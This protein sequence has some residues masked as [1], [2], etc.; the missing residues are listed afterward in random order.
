MGLQSCWRSW[1]GKST[2][3]SPRGPM[4]N[5]TSQP[6]VLCELAVP[7]FSSSCR[8]HLF[9]EDLSLTK[10]T[11]KILSSLSMNAVVAFSSPDFVSCSF[12][13]ESS[14]TCC[15]ASA[16]SKRE[17]FFTALRS[18]SSGQPSLWL[19]TPFCL[20]PSLV[21]PSSCS[22]KYKPRGLCDGLPQMFCFSVCGLSLAQDRAEPRSHQRRFPAVP[23]EE[24]LLLSL[25]CRLG[26][27]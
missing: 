10:H 9:P 14:H 1:E 26:P 12:E 16:G 21:L 22:I 23:A 13:F 18:L 3:G 11:V 4:V 25:V 19:Q 17:E 24:T 7:S 6:S 5:E 27:Q 20:Q 8:S 2:F 15:L